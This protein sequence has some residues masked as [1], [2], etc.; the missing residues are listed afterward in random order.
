MYTIHSKKQA[1]DSCLITLCWDQVMVD[2]SQIIQGYFTDTWA[3][4][5]SS[6]CQFLFLL[7][8]INSNSSMNK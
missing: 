4:V 1:Y 5:R 2:F 3:M 7:R 8:G 6:K